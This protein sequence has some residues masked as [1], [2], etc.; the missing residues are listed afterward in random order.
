MHP[1]ST[2]A[3]PA[4]NTKTIPVF[5]PTP[6]FLEFSVLAWSL[7]ANCFFIIFPFVFLFSVHFVV[8]GEVRMTFF[9]AR[10]FEQRRAFVHTRRFTK[11]RYPLYMRRTFVRRHSP[12]VLFINRA[13]KAF[14]FTRRGGIGEDVW[15][16]ARHQRSKRRP[17]REVV[18]VLQRQSE[19]WCVVD[20]E[21]YQ[22]IVRGR[23]VV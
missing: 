16:G 19:S 22:D 7:F 14:G 15:I 23:D 18:A 17:V 3:S 13:V 5:E 2:P 10:S 11:A 6:L 1:A 9:V 21:G 20:E 8:L 4:P 12:A